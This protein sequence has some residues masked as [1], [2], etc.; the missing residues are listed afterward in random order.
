MQVECDKCGCEYFYELARIGTGRASAPYGVG[1]TAA[2]DSAQDQS[3]RELSER[4]SLEA[5]LVPCPRCNWINDQLVEGYRKSCYRPAGTLALVVAFFGTIGSLFCAWFISSGPAADRAALPYFLY[6]GP[7]I[8]VLIAIAI[9]LVRWWMRRRIQPNQNYPLAPTLPVGSPLPLME[10][11]QTGDLKV[12]ARRNPHSLDV[13]DWFDFQIGRSVLPLMCCE[14]LGKPSSEDG[15]AR[16]IAPSIEINV[17]RCAECAKK[18]RSSRRRIWFATAAMG[19][20]VSF[21]VLSMLGLET[22]EYWILAVVGGFVA[23]AFA[24]YVASMMTAPVKI[25]RG[26]SSRGVIKLRFRN[27]EYGAAVHGATVHGATVHGATVRAG[28]STDGSAD[29]GFTF[30]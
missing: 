2:A 21:G 4:L 26:Q 22:A 24:S 14:C 16:S 29:S 30:Q 13:S 18:T 25:G 9:I 23:L 19:L 7:A 20:L 12:V 10:N 1:A 3:Q 5:E 8:S 11:P 27:P 15:Y 28:P 17:P 6:V